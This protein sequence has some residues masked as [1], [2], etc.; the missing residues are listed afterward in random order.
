MKCPHH[1]YHGSYEKDNQQ[2]N[3]ENEFK[4]KIPYKE[5]L[6]K[7]LRDANSRRPLSTNNM[8]STHPS[9]ESSTSSRS[10]SLS[11]VSS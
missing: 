8:L 5:R 10:F 2:A 1:A 11:S 7:T 4:I 3:Y 9:D 6:K